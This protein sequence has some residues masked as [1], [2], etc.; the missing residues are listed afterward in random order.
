MKKDINI[1]RNKK[2]AVTVAII[3][4]AVILVSALTGSLIAR[5]VAEKKEIAEVA[6]T[7]FHISSDYLEKKTDI[8]TPSKQ[9][10][11]TDW[12]Y[13]EDYQISFKVYNY[14][15]ENV[16]LITHN[17]IKYMINAGEDWDI[18]VKDKNGTEIPPSGDTYT[19]SSDGTANEHTVYL[20][21]NKDTVKTATVVV[22]TVEPFATSL[23]AV[24][25]LIGDHEYDVTFDDHTNYVRVIIDTNNYNGK[26]KLSW[27]SDFSPDNTNPIM[28]DWVD[29]ANGT[30]TA[31]EQTTYEL[32]F[33]KNS[34]GADPESGISINAEG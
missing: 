8:H 9:Y 33:F 27:N 11:V 5:Y 28:Q 13:S 23:Y 12:G 31:T 14:E 1:K 7:D 18:T 16:A 25:H 10:N 22:T 34:V 30:F 32:I 26:L 4:I 6:S 20:K 15:K 2:I 21:R 3:S 17:D 29:I 19:L 24:F